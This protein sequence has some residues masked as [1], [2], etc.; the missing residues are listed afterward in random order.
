MSRR[1]REA[2]EIRRDEFASRAPIGTPCLYFPIWPCHG[3]PFRVT[4]IRSEPWALGH[5]RVIVMV[6]GQAGGV[7][8]DHIAFG[9][10]TSHAKL[11]TAAPTPNALSPGAAI[12]AAL[13][14]MAD[15]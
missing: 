13:R 5:G 7:D 14:T 2:P 6:E 4:Q 15:A 9:P 8:I 10:A 11:A 1:E 3:H 12:L